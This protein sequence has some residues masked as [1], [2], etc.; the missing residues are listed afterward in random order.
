MRIPIAMAQFASL[1]GT[2]IALLPQ[3]LVVD[4][5]LVQAKRLLAGDDF[6]VVLDE[7]DATRTACS[8][9]VGMSTGHLV[10]YQV[11]NCGNM[12]SASE[13]EGNPRSGHEN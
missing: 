12:V 9:D 4:Q 5:H 8:M 7:M 10:R 13:R 1:F 11:P 3:E 6:G 2:A